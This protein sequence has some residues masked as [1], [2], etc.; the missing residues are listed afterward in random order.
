MAIDFRTDPA[1]YR[2]WRLSVEEPVATLTLNVVPDGGLAPGYE[3]KLNSYDLQVFIEL[4]DAVQR[5]RFSYPAISA[6]VLTSALPRTFCSGANIAMLAQSAHA[7]KVNFCKYCNETLAAI[8]DATA[9]SGQ[10]YLA[11]LNGSAAGGGY[12]IALACERILLADDGSSVVALPEIPVLG[13]LPGTG[14]LIRLTEKR[15]VRRDLADLFATT[16]EGIRGQRAVDWRLVDALAKPSAFDQAVRDLTTGLDGVADDSR[17]AGIELPAISVSQAGD[18]RLYQNVEVQL[19]RDAGTASLTITGPDSVPADPPALLAA[20]AAGWALA[21][22]RELDDAISHLR[23]NEPAI[24]TW[25]LRT[26]GDPALVQASDELLAG[27]PDW[28]AREITGLWR[29][30][31][32]RLDATS[33]SLFA[34]IEPG[35]CFTGTLLELALAA[36]RQY[37][38]AD[39]DGENGH[40]PASVGLTGMNYGPLAAAGGATRLRG[41]FGADTHALDA[42]AQATDKQLTAADAHALGLVTA[43]PDDMDWDDEIRLALSERASFSPDALSGMEANL[44]SSGPET[45]ETKIMGRL[46]AWQNW[47]FQRPNAAGQQGALR[48]YGTGRRP[49]YDRER[50]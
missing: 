37:L 26:R 15:G 49:Q 9:S 25:L 28:L 6:V 29:R 19:D 39:A 20:G 4:N 21:T 36:D 46:A 13:V 42:A 44:R 33:R 2:H 48:S 8:E 23:F 14:G 17:P 34:L 43:A 12:E 30:V 32:R 16:A 10:V 7:F 40:G 3:L 47:I 50:T 1:R 27:S 31:L 45:L 22:A 18:T 11:A 24:G 41:R 35:S 38:M 5:L